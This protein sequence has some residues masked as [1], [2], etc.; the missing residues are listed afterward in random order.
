MTNCVDTKQDTRKKIIAAIHPYDYTC[1]PQI[2]LKNQN[3][4]YENLINCFGKIK[5]I[6]ALLNTSFNFHGKPIVNT[7]EDAIDVFLNSDLDG[8]I[9]ENYFIFKKNL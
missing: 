7:A 1:R 8:L 6:Y 2:V 3:P 9:L 4:D 5:K